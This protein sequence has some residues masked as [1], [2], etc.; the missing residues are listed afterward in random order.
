MPR[1][2]ILSLVFCLF[3]GVV[4]AVEPNLI[5]KENEREPL[6][7]AEGFAFKG[8]EFKVARIAVTAERSED[9]KEEK[10]KNVKG[11][12][13]IGGYAFKLKLVMNGDDVLEADLIEMPD[14][15]S[16]M[17][18]DSEKKLEVPVGHVSLKAQQPDPKNRVFTGDLRVNSEKAEGINGTFELYLNDHT[19]KKMKKEEKGAEEKQQ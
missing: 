17:E 6:L 10:N 1:F 13:E 5:G 7:I 3:V 16:T 4:A 18:K 15:I 19:P 8:K 11:M 9:G 14:P 12:F 2:F